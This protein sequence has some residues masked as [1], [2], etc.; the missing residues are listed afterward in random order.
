MELGR[1]RTGRLVQAYTYTPLEHLRRFA[2]RYKVPLAL[3][4]LG[5]AAT[6]LVGAI[7]VVR[8]D[9]ERARAVHSE[10]VALDAMA[11]ANRDL[12]SMYAERADRHIREGDPLTGRAYA[13]ASVTLEDRP[14]ARGTLAS[15]W[16]E[17]GL[18]LVQRRPLPHPCEQLA[19]VGTDLLCAGGGT[20]S[21]L[22]DDRTRWS[23]PIGATAT[24][25]LTLGDTIWVGTS[26][27]TYAVHT[28]GTPIGRAES[29][30]NHWI[31]P[32]GPDEVMWIDR[33]RGQRSWA[34]WKVG[35]EPRYEPAS[36]SAVVGLAPHGDGTVRAHASGRLSAPGEGTIAKVD[37]VVYDLATVSDGW[38]LS[39][40]TSS[41]VSTR[42]HITDLP[43]I[44]EAFGFIQSNEHDQI[45]GVT[46][47]H[48]ILVYD[49]RTHS[50]VQELPSDGTRPG[51]LLQGSTLFTA[52]GT[53]LRTWSVPATVLR[54][55][56][57][58][59][60][61]M[62]GERRDGLQRLYCD[63][64]GWAELHD[65]P[66]GRILPLQGRRALGTVM[67]C[68]FEGAEA[69]GMWSGDQLW[70]DE[71]GFLLRSTHDGHPLSQSVA[72]GRF[73]VDE[74]EGVQ[75]RAGQHLGQ[76]II[77][78]ADDGTLLVQSAR[79]ELRW[80][81]DDGGDAL[82]MVR[83]LQLEEGERALTELP[84]GSVVIGPMGGFV[85]PLLRVD[86]AGQRHPIPTGSERI[87]AA[88]AIDAHHLVTGDQSGWLR[89]WDLR[90]GQLLAEH[91]AHQGRV[92]RLTVTGPPGQPTRVV[93]QSFDRGLAFLTVT[94][95]IA[96]L[97]Q[98]LDDARAR[99]VLEVRGGTLALRPLDTPPL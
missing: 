38:V 33:S 81:R 70:W 73:R 26:G 61:H 24:A 49:L 75:T 11:R 47:S 58:A 40:T 3:T 94:P 18:T 43:H 90:S 45:V 67:A 76:G 22:G 15:V 14:L 53:T 30:G 54:P 89:V 50:V 98:V 34:R 52:H 29:S 72:V 1:W 7:G 32:I 95:L 80:W 39:G 92:F 84:D 59:S 41:H 57:D 37:H 20:L 25:I 19:A 99:E 55:S 77:R 9:A 12:A 62:M 46:A 21:R 5:L 83:R 85:R 6:L 44:D 69:V 23:V 63:N 60:W 17:R 16:E 82:A 88:A 91:A 8:I 13:L 96:P 86:P 28:D 35:E 2:E 64:G 48:T 27:G 71:D 36:G 97:A 68:Q 65:L 66:S 42:G 4:G 78:Q 79:G 10:K 93:S 56:V 74:I 87:T 31:Q 51:M